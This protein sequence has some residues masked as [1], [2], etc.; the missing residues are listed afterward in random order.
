MSVITNMKTAAKGLGINAFITDSDKGIETQLRSLTRDESL[1]IMLISWDMDRELVFDDNGFLRSNGVKVVCLLL[2]KPEDLTKS[3]AEL[4][5]ESMGLLF[6]KFIIAL[7][8]LIIPEIPPTT[9]PI[10]G[11]GYKLTPWYGVH[12]HSGIL[13]RFTMAYAPEV[14]CS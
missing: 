3:V 13:G 4:A 1:P 6:E 7:R 14:S 10:S 8:S 9:P 11:A 12:K 5:A 2:T